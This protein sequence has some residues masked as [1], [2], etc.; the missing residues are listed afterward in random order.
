MSKK[1][2]RQANNTN[3]LEKAVNT[4][5]DG[6]LRGEQIIHPQYG[7][8]FITDITSDA[9]KISARFDFD[10]IIRTIALPEDLPL[11]FSNEQSEPIVDFL[12]QVFGRHECE[13]CGKRLF[14]QS[15]TSEQKTI[16]QLYHLCEQ[17][18]SEKYEC[19]ICN[20]RFFVTSEVEDKPSSIKICHS[21]FQYY[22]TELPKPEKWEPH[23]FEYFQALSIDRP[24]FNKYLIDCNDLCS[25]FHTYSIVQLSCGINIANAKIVLKF[26]KELTKPILTRIMLVNG[27]SKELIDSK[28]DTF[29][30]YRLCNLVYCNNDVGGLFGVRCVGTSSEFRYVIESFINNVK[31][32][33]VWIRN[34]EHEPLH[35][36]VYEDYERAINQLWPY[37]YDEPEWREEFSSCEEM[38][39]FYSQQDFLPNYKEMYEE[40]DGT[41]DDAFKAINIQ[42]SV[43]SQLNN[44]MRVLYVCNGIIHCEQDHHKIIPIRLTVPT[45]NNGAVEINANYCIDCDFL[46]IFRNDY[47]YFRDRYG[48]PLIPFKSFEDTDNAN[49]YGADQSILYLSG[50]S[51]S[52]T[53]NLS[54]EERQQIL[55]NVVAAGILPKPRIIMY[56][57]WFIDHN[58]RIPGH[59]RAVSKWQEDLRFVYSLDFEKQV[60][61]YADRIARKQE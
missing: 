23:P 54:A 46:Y 34:R 60:K 49:E 53:S 45:M 56:L 50:Y 27:A 37:S 22:F 25:I 51:V 52:T 61:M 1:K 18:D 24:R 57:N 14:P 19:P 47:E 2:K 12:D 42:V 48:L 16:F 41:L 6:F 13:R 4:I 5:P 43:Q 8:G 31:Q 21:C 35:A 29:P 26:L 17:C 3:N 30:L 36:I 59:E 9:T 15:F 38:A 11:L 44:K 58:G 20:D 7:H 10:G 39:D 40:L 28:V 55:A 33:G 32:F